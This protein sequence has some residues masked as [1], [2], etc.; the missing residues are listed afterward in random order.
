EEAQSY[1][2]IVRATPL[3][4]V[5]PPYRGELRVFLADLAINEGKASDCLK[6]AQEA[7]SW[8]GHNESFSRTLALSLVGQAQRLLREFNGAIHTLRQ[9]VEWGRRSGNHL[10]GLNALAIWRRSYTFRGDGSKP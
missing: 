9:V 10:V 1:A 6:L 5:P 4:D 3:D 7:L 2:A 8:F